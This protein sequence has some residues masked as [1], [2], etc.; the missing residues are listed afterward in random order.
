MKTHRL[1]LSVGA[2]T[3]ALLL[4]GCMAAMMPA[5]LLG[6]AAHNKGGTS[7][8]QSPK[9]CECEKPTAKPDAQATSAARVDEKPAT[10]PSGGHQH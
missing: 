2:L 5:M 7:H 1:F 3:C 4:S 10:P 8:E 6:H 9:S